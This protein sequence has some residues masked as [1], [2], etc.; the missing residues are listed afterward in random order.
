MEDLLGSCTG[1]IFQDVRFSS[2]LFM[3]RIGET[4]TCC[5]FSIQFNSGAENRGLRRFGFADLFLID[6]SWRKTK[7][8]KDDELSKSMRPRSAIS[9]LLVWGWRRLARLLQDIIWMKA[10]FVCPQHCNTAERLRKVNSEKCHSRSSIVHWRSPHDD[11]HIL[12][13]C[14]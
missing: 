11:T 5:L 9:S 3:R 4:L 10:F 1:D 6:F 12:R 8:R 7:K 2:I 13:N 14:R